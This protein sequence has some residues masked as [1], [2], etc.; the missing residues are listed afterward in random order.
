MDEVTKE[1]IKKEFADMD[2]V[3]VAKL[4]IPDTMYEVRPSSE[5][6][7][8]MKGRM[9][10]FE[11]FAVDKDIEQ[12]IIKNP[13]EPELYKVVRA[14]GMRTIKEDALLKALKGDI[15]IQEVFGFN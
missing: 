4:N 9:P 15:V 3:A 6:P 10:V 11:M 12:A 5:S 14:K 13:T 1:L 8:G 7:S 2:P